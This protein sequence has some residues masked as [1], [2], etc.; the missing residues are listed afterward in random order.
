MIFTEMKLSAVESY[1]NTTAGAPS[2]VANQNAKT[3]GHPKS[4]LNYFLVTS[5][6]SLPRGNRRA[7]GAA[8]GEGEKSTKF[9]NTDE[10]V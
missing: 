4:H 3:W 10:E 7:A 1:G 6:N 9:Q 8:R 2:R 5:R